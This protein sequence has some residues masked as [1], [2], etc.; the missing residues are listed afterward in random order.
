MST[1][2]SVNTR[3]INSIKDALGSQFFTYLEEDD[4]TEIMRNPNGTLWVERV[5]QG[6]QRVGTITDAATNNVIKL[7]SSLLEKET[8]KD[9][10]LLEGEFPIG[11]HR[12]AAQLPPVVSA[13]AFSIRKKINQTFTLEWY[14]EQGEMTQRQYQGLIETIKE[15]ENVLISGGTSSGKTTFANAIIVKIL[16]LNS[17]TRILS[18]EDTYE[19]VVNGEN[20]AQYH[21]SLEVSQTMLVKTTLRMKP[22]WLIIGEVRGEE[23]MDLLVAF[24]SG[25]SGFSTIHANDCM[26]ALIKFQTLASM[27][28]NAPSILGRMIADCTHIVIQMHLDDFTKKRSIKEMKKVEKYDK[29]TGEIILSDL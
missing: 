17:Q 14:L 28:N 7:V 8:K 1:K 13:P 22:T 21:T 20:C 6:M 10:P 5:G 2:D 24:N 16:E 4:V 23:A 26:G 19:L 18:V 29:A 9:S 27:R 12:F 3:T 25:H 11:G 15:G